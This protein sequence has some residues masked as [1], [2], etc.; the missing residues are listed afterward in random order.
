MA[1]APSWGAGTGTKE[2]LNWL[3]SVKGQACV[4]AEPYFAGGSAGGAE[5]VGVSDLA[6]R[7]RS[8]GKMPSD[9]SNTLYG[10]VSS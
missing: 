2:P 6:P 8:G 3:E 4:M 10:G 5:D 7:S 9:L 1:V